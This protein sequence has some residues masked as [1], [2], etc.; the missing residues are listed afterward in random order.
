MADPLLALDC[1]TLEELDALTPE[2]L[3][4]LLLDCDLYCPRG[5]ET[6]SVNQPNGSGRNY[7]FVAPSDDIRDLFG[8]FYLSYEDDECAFVRPFSLCWLFGFGTKILLPPPG[9][10]GP[11][12][13]KEILVCDANGAVVFDSTTAVDYAEVDWAGRMLV[14]EWKTVN[15]VARIVEHTCWGTNTALPTLY[16]EYIV[17]DNGELDTRT[18]N[19]LPRRLRTVKVGLS[20]FGGGDIQL[21]EGFNISLTPEANPVRTD[22]GRFKTQ[23]SIRARPGDGLGRRPGCDEAEPVIKRFNNI[24]PDAAGDFVLDAANC[25]R[26]QRPMELTSEAPRQVASG[27]AA[28]ASKLTTLL[29]A[30]P[31]NLINADPVVAQAIRT[32][33]LADPDLS[34]ASALQLY[35]DCS[36]CCECEDFVN[37][38]E[39]LRR[40]YNNYLSIGDRAEET[41]DKHQL[42]VDR[43]NAQRDCRLA[44]AL[45]LVLSQEFRCKLAVGAL[46]CNQTLGCITPLVIRLTFLVNFNGSPDASPPNELVL[47]NE[48]KRKGSD[49]FDEHVGHVF[50]GSFPVV[51]TYYDFVNPQTTASLTT[52]L[53]FPGCENGHALDVVLSVHAPDPINPRTGVPIPWL[54]P[55]APLPSWVDAAWILNPTPYKVIGFVAKKLPLIPDAACRCD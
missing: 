43:W 46:F 35:N 47:C 49:T 34:A 50:A 28:Y 30:V 44:N 1:L 39:G 26:A 9:F 55:S 53:S 37:T 54:L 10:P 12:N 42:N 18:Y 15:G 38:Y 48:T 41:R 23:L 32:A 36:P 24:P 45:R 17:P 2:E 25:Y 14:I 13:P 16:D 20:T 11:V 33:L 40:V 29:N 3:E 22:G 51:D 52:R 4:A 7:P 27:G 6:I 31:D 8:D 5:R 21:L 19:Q